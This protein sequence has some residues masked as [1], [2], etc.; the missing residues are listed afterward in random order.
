VTPHWLWR[1]LPVSL[2]LVAAVAALAIHQNNLGA[3]FLAAAFM[4]GVVFLLFG[5]PRSR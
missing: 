5:N 2:A 4:L 3:I 1:V